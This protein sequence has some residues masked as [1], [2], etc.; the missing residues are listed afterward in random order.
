MCV[1]WGGAA[2]REALW[3]GCQPAE[4][5]DVAQ[6]G[7]GA[8]EGKKSRARP[9]RE[10]PRLAEELGLE[11]LPG[12]LGGGQQLWC[13]VCG[14]HVCGAETFRAHC[15]SRRHLGKLKTKATEMLQAEG[16]RHRVEA[17]GEGGREAS[18]PKRPNSLVGKHANT[19]EYCQQ[20]L[21]DSP[22][23][24][25]SLPFCASGPLL[26]ARDEQGL[27]ACWR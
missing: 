17:A 9:A 23:R 22:S 3:I 27:T 26:L 13:S 16:A 18:A 20:V 1:R 25:L 19:R 11:A 21:V 10:L 2:V 6:E 8:G 5:Q 4:F 14:V 7:S 24:A 15:S 12:R